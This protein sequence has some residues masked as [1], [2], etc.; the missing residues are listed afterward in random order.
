MKDY[1]KSQIPGFTV[2]AGLI[3]ALAITLFTMSRPAPIRDV[4][5][6]TITPG[7]GAT[8]R[9][10]ESRR[11]GDTIKYPLSYDDAGKSTLNVPVDSIPEARAWRH[12]VWATTMLY[13]TDGTTGVLKGYRWGNIE[14]SGGVWARIPRLQAPLHFRMK[15]EPDAGLAFAVTWHSESPF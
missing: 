4:P 1:L 7:T 5:K 2:G 12:N 10:D 14:L 8:A 9:V 6:A 15:S 3:L 11:D 13:L